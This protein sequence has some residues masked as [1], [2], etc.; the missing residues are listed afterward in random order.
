MSSVLVMK[1]HDA[2]VLGARAILEAHLEKAGV[3]LASA[4]EAAPRPEPPPLMHPIDAR[5]APVPAGYKRVYHGHIPHQ[6]AKE[7]ARRRRQQNR[8]EVL[9]ARTDLQALLG[10]FIGQVNTPEVREEITGITLAYIESLGPSNEIARA[11]AD[12]LLAN[13]GV[14]P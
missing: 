5:R 13:M 4:D 14:K 3:V 6:G 2:A 12:T 1:G 10:R 8:A 7:T 9:K 11:F